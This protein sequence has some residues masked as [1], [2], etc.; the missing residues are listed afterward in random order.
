MNTRIIKYSVIAIL[1]VLFVAASLILRQPANN[2]D[3]P[4]LDSTSS[5][6]QVT[7][8]PLTFLD[9]NLPGFNRLHNLFRSRL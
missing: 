3:A 1:L 9:Q 6:P 7:I 8:H 2:V 5:Q 4:A